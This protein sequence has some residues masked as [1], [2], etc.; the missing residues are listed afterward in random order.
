MSCIEK[1][2]HKECGGND[3]QVF[4]DGSGY[5][6]YCFNCAT[7]V[8]DPYDGNTPVITRRK[9]TEED[10]R[11]ELADIS[12]LNC[13]ELPARRLEVS[14]L[15]YFNIKVGVSEADGVTPAYVFFPYYTTV[16]ELSYKA[17]VLPTKHMW[18]I[19]D[20]FKNANL[21]GWDQ[22][23][24]TGARKLFITEGE[25]DT[26]ALWQSLRNKQRGTKWENNYPA[27]VSLRNGASGVEKDL[28]KHAS[29]IQRRFKE[30]VLVFD[31]D[32]AGKKA[33]ERAI[34][35][36]PNASA[37]TLPAKDA[38]ECLILG[39]SLA[40]CN[41][42]LFN[43]ST[44]KNSHLINAATLYEAARQPAEWG[45]SW[46]WDGMTRLTRGI[47]PGEVH[48]IGAGVKMGKSELLN[49]I[50]THMMLEHNMKVL[51]AKPEEANKKTVKMVLSKAVGKI[52]H[53]PTVEFNVDDYNKAASLVGDKL[54]LLDLYQDLR[55][56]NLR[57][58]IVEVAQEG[59]K[60]IF[61]DP[62][63]YLIMGTPA[64]EADTVLQGITQELAT[65][66]KD[67]DLFVFI[68]CHLKAPLTGDPHERGGQIFS[69]QFTGSRA[70]MRCCHYMYGLWGNKDPEL[71]INQR[72]LRELIILEDREFGVAE[73]VKLFWD[74]Q[75]AL[76][77][78]VR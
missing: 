41:A 27:V 30:V 68:F 55:W 8:P 25:F 22:A 21:F 20:G 9:K 29:E 17:R 3:L 56:N 10:I 65:L 45:L 37:A 54:Y 53:D 69:N 72:N 5:T 64:S 48:Y 33:V 1:I 70:M 15:E 63:S 18:T 76:F 26:C 71:P 19:G 14:T 4:S 60:A 28:T 36:L 77:N 52:F 66:A 67:L 47:R 49:A 35:I 44:P 57:A 13:M 34:Q 38:N 62:L 6:G 31:Q 7:Y 39:R 42:V 78:E 73:K 24:A 61:I 75:T 58:D 32:E 40:L 51:L 46:P 11:K 43:S 74:S 59:A 16:S 2:V 12:S 23:I 50:A